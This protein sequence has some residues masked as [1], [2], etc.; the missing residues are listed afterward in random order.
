MAPVHYK[1]TIDRNSPD[2]ACAALAAHTGLSKIRI[3]RAMAHGA[4]WLQKG[5]GKLHRLRRATATVRPGDQLHFYYDPDLLD[6]VPPAA[7]CLEDFG[8]YSI[9]FKP[10]GLLTQGTRF[11]DHCALSRQVEHHYNGKREVFLVHRLDREASGLLI[12]AHSSSAAARFSKLLREHGVEKEYRIAVR[13][14]LARSQSAGCIDLVLDGKQALTTYEVL[15]YDPEADRS[16]VRVRLQTGRF[17]QI[18]RHFA[19]IGYPVLGDPRYGRNNKNR[20]G[21]ALVACAVS[22]ECPYGRRQ[23]QVRIDPG[24][25]L[26]EP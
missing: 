24:D 23:I 3:K 1:V 16:L 13:G 17:H 15:Q 18:R 14:D 4:V 22:F 9:W 11:G 7:R 26:R 2:T 6:G 8:P 25:T 12:V 20:T 5:P 10:A 19:A 21:M